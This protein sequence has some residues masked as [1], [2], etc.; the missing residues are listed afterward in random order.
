MLDR[1]TVG[2]PRHSRSA[3]AARA[4]HLRV[5]A[6]RRVSYAHRSIVSDVQVLHLNNH[7]AI[8][9]SMSPQ[10][11]MRLDSSRDTDVGGRRWERLGVRLAAV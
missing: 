7:R 4:V 10:P 11:G 6:A 9:L 1:S 3:R 5:R 2:A 8:Y